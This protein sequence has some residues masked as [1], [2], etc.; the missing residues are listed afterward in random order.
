MKNPI[1]TSLRG[2]L[3]SL[4][5]IIVVFIFSI[6]FFNNFPEMVP[7]HWNMNGEVDGW[8]NRTVAAFVLPS[9]ILGTYL[10]FL[11]LPMID[12]KKERYGQ[13]SRVYQVFKN[14]IIFFMVAMYFISSFSALGYNVSVQFWIPF[15]VGMLFVL[16]GNYMAKIKM[17]WFVG[18][19]TPWTLSSEKVW[20]KTHRFGGKIFILGGLII[21]FMNVFP[22]AWRL[23][24][25][26]VNILVMTLGVFLY[27]YIIFIQ[28]KKTNG[29]KN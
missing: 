4:F 8:S 16:L 26:I 13:F 9:I 12:P 28:E 15:L 2:E 19:K 1:Q 20:N 5:P 24:I 3:F 22:S 25:F 6:H 14:A 18:I 23:P 21:A 10:L 29:R 7:T 11:V 27:S 17:N